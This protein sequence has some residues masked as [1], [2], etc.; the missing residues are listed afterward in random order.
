MFTGT[1][2]VPMFTII[3]AG[4]Y[5]HSKQSKAFHAKC[6]FKVNCEQ[7]W[8]WS[9]KLIV[10]VF[11]ISIKQSDIWDV[12]DVCSKLHED[13]HDYCLFSM[14]HQLVVGILFSCFW[15]KNYK[16]V[17]SRHSMT[18]KKCFC[19]EESLNYHKMVW[20]H[21]NRVCLTVRYHKKIVK[22]DRQTVLSG[23]LWVGQ[24]K[25]RSLSTS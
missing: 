15:L 17:V 16:N 7:K 14:S 21:S 1:S 5:T 25:S 12:V 19:V 20:T 2:L 22:V 23:L 13:S 3:S 10:W 18:I 11:Q 24:H 9:P 6:N 4:P 8:V